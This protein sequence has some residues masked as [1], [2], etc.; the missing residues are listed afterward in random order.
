MKGKPAISPMGVQ[1]GQD[2]T[3]SFH[4]SRRARPGCGSSR[5]SPTW[6]PRIDGCSSSSR[7]WSGRTV[8]LAIGT[9]KGTL[10]KAPSVQDGAVFEVASG[11]TLV[12]EVATSDE[13]A[14]FEEFR[15]RLGE[16][17]FAADGASVDFVSPFSGVAL[18][19]E[20]DPARR[21]I[22]GEPV[23]WTA[24]QVSFS[25]PWGSHSFGTTHGVGLATASRSSGTGIPTGRAITRGSR[26]KHRDQRRRRAVMSRGSRRTRRNGARRV[27]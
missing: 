8:Y 18:H 1:V 24:Y 25:S 23:D 7:S 2:G 6:S 21:T 5:P 4:R 11:A 16:V 14:S 17:D 27:R 12:W 3:V 19:L 20:N 15:Q 10:T 22:D 9:S 13:V 26:R